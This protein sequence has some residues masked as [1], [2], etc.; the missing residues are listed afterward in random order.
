MSVC[1]KVLPCVCRTRLP[2]IACG[3]G[4]RLVVHVKSWRS[5]FMCCTCVYHA[6]KWTLPFVPLIPAKARI[7][8]PFRIFLLSLYSSLAGL[9]SLHCLHSGVQFLCAIMFDIYFLVKML[10][11]A[12]F[13]VKYICWWWFIS[14]NCFVLISV[15]NHG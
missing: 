15:C 2:N 13:D 10:Y 3:Y 7:S 11:V 12:Y 9:L 14:R 5:T 4:S 8:T 6:T 1:G